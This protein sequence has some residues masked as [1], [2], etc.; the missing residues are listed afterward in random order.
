MNVTVT[1]PATGGF[2]TVYPN[3]STEPTAS[4]LNFSAGQNI[5]N[6]AAV[7]V[8]GNGRIALANNSAGSVHLIADVAG[9][10]LGSPE[11]LDEVWP[12]GWIFDDCGTDWD[13]LLLV[14]SPGIVYSPQPP[15]VFWEGETYYDLLP[16]AAG[17]IV[18]TVSAEKGYVVAI[19]SD[20]TDWAA[21]GDGS[22][23]GTIH[24]D[25]GSC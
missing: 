4:N 22:Y 23:T 1:E 15:T 17:E 14:A 25:V 6:L 5:P 18:V 21:N 10:F 8:G 2:I 9:Y 19:S 24:F 12:S 20:A 16:G 3:G 13:E 7:K 11:D